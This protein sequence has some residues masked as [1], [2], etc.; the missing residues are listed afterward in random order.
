MKGMLQVV[1]L[2]IVAAVISG[3]SGVQTKGLTADDSLALKDKSVAVARYADLPD[4]A[5]QTAVNVQFGMIGYATAVSNGNA[6]IRNQKIA[7]PA[8][9]IAQR[10]GEGLRGQHNVTISEPAN[11]V[12]HKSSVGD[13]VK[14]YGDHDFILDVKTVGWRSIYFPSDWNNYKV[15]YAAHARLIDAKTSKVVSEGVCTHMPEYT[16]TDSAPSYEALEDGTGL[17]AAL[18]GSIDYCVA[19]IRTKTGMPAAAA[20]PRFAVTSQ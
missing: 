15:I 20:Q 12:M 10:L 14:A 7:D 3:C 9:T 11:L 16:D 17:R 4:F 8:L 6:I 18:A 5:A 13:I 19:D 1:G 2:G